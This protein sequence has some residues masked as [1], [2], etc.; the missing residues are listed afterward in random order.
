MAAVAMRGE[1]HPW[2]SSP[3]LPCSSA[4]PADPVSSEPARE[5][6]RRAARGG[7]GGQHEELDTFVTGSSGRTRTVARVFDC[8]RR[9]RAASDPARRTS[10]GTRAAGRERPASAVEQ[11]S[12]RRWNCGG[13]RGDGV[14]RG[15]SRRWWG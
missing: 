1:I 15:G 3:F 14:G 8:L 4:G 6:G 2:P 12:S 13:G 11:G 9:R 5:Q 7:T 10:R